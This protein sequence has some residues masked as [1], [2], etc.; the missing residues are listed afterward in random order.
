MLKS[1]LFLIAALIAFGQ[2]AIAQ[3]YVNG[4]EAGVYINGVPMTEQDLQTLET[5]YGTVILDGSYWYDP[6]SGSLVPMDAA[7]TSG[8]DSENEPEMSAAEQIALYMLVGAALNANSY[9]QGAGTQGWYGDQGVGG[10][11]GNHYGSVYSE[12]GNTRSTVA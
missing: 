2:S 3:S 10:W 9:Y 4:S 1:I 5:H 12:V 8:A 6:M 11:T 7:I